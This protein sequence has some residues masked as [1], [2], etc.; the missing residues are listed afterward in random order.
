VSPIKSNLI[1]SLLNLD[2]ERQTVLNS[3]VKAKQH[4]L[5]SSGFFVFN[6][7]D[8]KKMTEMSPKNVSSRNLNNGRST[9][10]NFSIAELEN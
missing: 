9:S 6:E 1:D 4:K 2:A 5:N 8:M 7:D 3:T 10:L